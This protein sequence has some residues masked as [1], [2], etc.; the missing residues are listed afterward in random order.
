MLILIRTHGPGGEF[1]P[2]RM[3]LR[4]RAACLPSSVVLPRGTMRRCILVFEPQLEFC[5]VRLAMA[6]YRPS[7]CDQVDHGLIPAASTS[8]SQSRIN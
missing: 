1:G 4:I 7:N 5:F 6:H 3:P 8:H 2:R